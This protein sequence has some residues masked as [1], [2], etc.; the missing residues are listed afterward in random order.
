MNGR[1]WIGVRLGVG[2]NLS[3]RTNEAGFEL[4]EGAAGAGEGRGGRGQCD[5]DGGD[6]RDSAHSCN[7]DV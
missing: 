1:K 4:G 7:R 5:G 3:C 6:E 2:A